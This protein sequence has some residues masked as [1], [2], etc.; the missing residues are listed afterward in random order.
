MPTYEFKCDCGNT[1]EEIQSI[2]L[3][4]HESKCI[5][6]GKVC[7]SLV[8]GGGGFAF[9]NHRNWNPVPGFPGNDIQ[10]NK[11]AKKIEKEMEKQVTRHAGASEQQIAQAQNKIKNAGKMARV[12]KRGKKK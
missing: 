7:N 11:H 2:R 8:T 5:K 12:K 6:C 10:V 9:V 1:W 4:N 3:E